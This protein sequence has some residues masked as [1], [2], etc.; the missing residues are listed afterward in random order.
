MVA[1]QGLGE[2]RMLLGHEHR[3]MSGDELSDSLIM[4]GVLMV[5][6]SAGKFIKEPLEKRLPSGTAEKL[7]LN[8]AIAKRLGML[9]ADRESIRRQVDN[10][11]EGEGTDAEVAKLLA[12]TEKLWGEELQL[13]DGAGLDK[14]ELDGALA[15]YREHVAGMQ[16]RLSQ[17]GIESPAPG[18]TVFRPVRVGL[19]AFT[20]EGRA[21]LD[22][23]YD[24]ADPQMPGKS[25]TESKTMPNVLEGRMPGG[26]VTYYVPEASLATEFAPADG[27]TGAVPASPAAAPVPSDVP[28][29]AASTAPQVVTKEPSIPADVKPA[30]PVKALEPST[31]V[32]AGVPTA[33]VKTDEPLQGPPSAEQ[34]PRSSRPRSSRPR[35]SRPRSSRPRP[36]RIC[37]PK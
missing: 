33:P 3:L 29:P 8:K 11:S 20:P 5:A 24:P 21:A 36:R 12:D 27:P 37:K 34:R 23:F 9:A 6:L 31:E 26:E 2:L 14:G 19:T 32:N 15:A 25:L 22:Q 30:E 10:L 16:L 13:I 17:I 18:G 7:G 4:N 35:S 28:A 1:L